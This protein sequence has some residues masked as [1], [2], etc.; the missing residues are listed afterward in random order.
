MQAAFQKDTDCG[1]SKTINL[2]A[3]SDRETVRQA[4][5]RAYSQGVKGITVYR[6]ES[7]EL[8][9]LNIGREGKK[10]NLCRYRRDCE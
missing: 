9:V 6:D 2:P 1:V 4:Y 5:L 7:R 10:A 8:Q 3:D